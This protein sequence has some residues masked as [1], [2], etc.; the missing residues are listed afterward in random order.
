MI[1]A[2]TQE[3]FDA[4][5]PGKK[6]PWQKWIAEDVMYFDE[7]GHDMNKKS[8]L[9]TIE[10]LPSG[11]TGTIK[12]VHSKINVQGNTLIHS[13]DLDESEN[14]HGQ[15]LHARYH[16]TDT[17]MQRGGNWQIIA[18]QVLRYYED[19]A[20]GLAD[21]RK[22]RDYAG[23]YTLA[24]EQELVSAEGGKLYLTRGTRPRVEL[25]P[26]SGDI[27]F[28]RGKEGRILFHYTGGRV[29]SLIDRRNNEDVIWGRIR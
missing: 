18:G 4:V 14:V 22:F 26:E 19:P 13:Y 27:F 20:P 5:A 21:P 6:E 29:D 3:L 1:L 9:D 28:R 11:L 10:P 17:W 24:N 25:L 23:T 2:R 12:V 16:A 15:E 7:Q 8:L